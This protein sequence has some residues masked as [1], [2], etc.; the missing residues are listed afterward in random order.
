MQPSYYPATNWSTFLDTANCA[1]IYTSP[2]IRFLHP[3]RD[4]TLAMQ[5]SPD[6][7]VIVS[8]NVEH[9]VRVP[10]QRPRAQPWQVQFVS[11]ARRS[12]SSVAAEMG[13]RFLQ[14]INEAQG[15]GVSVLA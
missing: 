2:R 14:R 15:G 9:D 7:N 13:V 6:V 11:V 8:I 3:R 12:C 4:V 10:R 1:A 5:Y